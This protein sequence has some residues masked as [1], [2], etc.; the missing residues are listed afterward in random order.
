MSK[1]LKDWDFVGVDNF[2]QLGRAIYKGTDCGPWVVARRWDGSKVYYEDKKATEIG[3]THKV[4]SVIVG[5]IVEGY[6][7]EVPS[8]E[9]YS[10][11]DL[12]A[13]LD[14]IDETCRNVWD[15]V[16]G[17][18]PTDDDYMVVADVLS[19]LAFDLQH[20]GDVNV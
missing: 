9:V 15:I 2:Y 14:L 10:K 8:V 18:D 1:K 7:G 4:E 16:N 11:K 17:E 5:S 20:L 12:I 19:G 6:D 3:P 13:A